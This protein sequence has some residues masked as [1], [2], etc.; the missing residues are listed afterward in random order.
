MS[1]ARP[2]QMALTKTFSESVLASLRTIQL[3]LDWA[4][5][6]SLG[7]ASRIVAEMVR[8]LRSAQILIG[9]AASG[10]STIQRSRWAETN[11]SQSSLSRP[12]W[13]VTLGADVSFSC[14]VPPICFR[15]MS[16]QRVT[17]FLMPS[18][19][20]ELHRA[21]A[22]VLSDLEAFRE[23][24]EHQVFPVPRFIR[25]KVRLR[26]HAGVLRNSAPACGHR[27]HMRCWQEN[28]GLYQC[29][30]CKKQ[31]S[32]TAGTMLPR[33]MNQGDAAGTLYGS[34]LSDPCAGS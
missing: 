7:A 24:F 17:L 4:V 21:S 2:G 33:P 23:A 10:T 15:L 28:R 20:T 1:C 29:N 34:P 30:R 3:I 14:H 12:A 11:C 19:S 5:F 8:R 13:S 25:S 22:A 26:W 18:G 31:T 16:K 27:E 6:L 32:P 9:A